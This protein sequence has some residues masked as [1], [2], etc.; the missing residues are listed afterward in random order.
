VLSTPRTGV[1]AVLAA[2]VTVA[3]TVS[4]GPAATA[5]HHDPVPTQEQVDRAA[6]AVADKTRDAAAIQASLLLANQRLE[7]ASMLAEVA[8][9]KYNA[10]MWHLSEA[11]AEVKKA[12]ARAAAAKQAVA[13]QRDDIAALVTQRYRGGAQLDQLN[14]LFSSDGPSGVMDGYGAVHSVGDTMQAAFDRYRAANA[15]AKVTLAKAFEAKATAQRMAAG[16]RTARDRAT[17]A[18]NEAQTAASSIAAEKSRLLDELATAQGISVRL[19]TE[20]QSALEEQARERA[21]AA[22][23]ARAEQ[24]AHEPAEQRA[25]QPERKHS[26]SPN[27][28]PSPHLSPGPPP[29]PT[30]S[31]SQP[32]SPAPTPPPSPAPSPPPAPSGGANQAI[33][34]AKAQIGEP[35]SWGAAG[36]GSWDC[37]GLTMQAWASAGRSLPHWSVGQYQ[38]TSHISSSQLRPGDLLFWG[39]SSS[40]SSIHHVAMYLGGG[41][42]IHAPRTGQ[43]VQIASMYYWIPPNFFGRP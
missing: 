3:V 33:A 1:R 12:D 11:R 42:M 32:P 8:A 2:A 6:G 17:S 38:A 41:M 27:P 34:F 16:A 22:A 7:H 31:P 20:R 23:R 37:S 25:T 28:K 4:F 35:Y 10:A 39:T 15:L 5:D 14:A 26:S 13:D 29:S 30:P 19:A 9:E 43:D 40:S 36:P 21:A 24:E 18:A